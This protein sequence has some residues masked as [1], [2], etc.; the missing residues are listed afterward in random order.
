M[1][2]M[3]WLLLSALIIVGDFLTK[4]LALT[5]LMLHEPVPITPF[6]NLTLIYNSG[7]AFGFLNSGEPS[8]QRWLLTAVSV[9]ATILFYRWFQTSR[10][11]LQRAAIALVMGG[12]VGNLI[13][14]A[15]TGYVVDFIQVHGAGYYFPAFNIADAA[16]CVGVGLLLIYWVK[17][18]YRH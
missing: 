12:A 5:H 9:I 16:I 13:D 3:C 14:R 4:Q 6:F 17:Y 7:A 15:F 10:D 1:R 2:N 11:N 8:W 18:E